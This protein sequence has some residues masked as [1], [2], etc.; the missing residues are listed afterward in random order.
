MMTS[1]NETGPAPTSS[2]SERSKRRVAASS[3]LAAV[4]LTAGKAAVG[5][6]TGSL[7]ILSEAAHSG[8]DL[9]AAAATWLAVRV[10]GRPADL[11]HTYGHG[12][13]E[14][15]AA[16][17]ETA[18]L[19]GTC[20]WIIWEA[21][22]R[23]LVRQVHV[24][25][26]AWAFAVM[27]AS[28]GVDV[29]RSRALRRVA[30]ATG[31]QALEADALHFSTDIWSSGVV[32]FGL[33]AVR[34]SALPGLRWLAHADTL[35]AL[36]V[37]LI[38][39]M[40]SLRLG[41]RTLAELIDEVPPGLLEEL[42]AAVAV[43]G[44]TSVGR[45]RVRRS[46]PQAFADVELVVPRNTSLT[47]AHDIATAAELAVRALLP[48]ADVVV[49]VEPL[50]GG[51]A[52]DEGDVV[53]LVRRLAVEHDLTAHEL[54]VYEL[55]GQ[56]SIELHLEVDGDLSVADAH[57]Q[58]SAFEQALRARLPDVGEIVSHLEPRAPARSGN[59]ER[60]DDTALLQAVL[61]DVIRQRGLDCSPHG[62]SVQ[63]SGRDLS[64][65][66]HCV[67]AA[68][69]SIAQAHA[70]TDEVEQALRARLP[71]LERVTIH[72]EPAGSPAP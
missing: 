5:V 38:V 6:L 12:K 42:R 29:S 68:D 4:A 37:A 63:R 9:I 18:L 61:L 45:L 7:G 33:A 70:L 53:A 16:L 60:M 46:G 15:L 23:L 66:F 50:A 64:A 47:G 69:M 28:I 21:V 1:G 41:R 22:A 67:T 58:A 10:S 3:V 40:V 34:A 13:V 55:M 30:R 35:A 62:I 59:R 51:G 2:E 71:E 54:R 20:V 24:E 72:V 32:I 39:I 17:L 31:S 56:R 8:L 14:N 57:A 25:A 48:G 52:S 26:N 44:V 11:R 65:S 36:G 43:P 27:V 49:H 19:L